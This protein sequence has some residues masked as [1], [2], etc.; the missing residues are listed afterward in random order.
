ME[1]SRGRDA[2]VPVES[3]RTRYVS[4]CFEQKRAV[5]ALAQAGYSARRGELCFRA[6][7]DQGL[8]PGGRAEI[9][10]VGRSGNLARWA[11]VV[12]LRRAMA[13]KRTTRAAQ[14]PANVIGSSYGGDWTG[15]RI[16][17]GRRGRE[18]SVLTNRGDAAGAARIVR[19]D[20][21]ERTRLGFVNGARRLG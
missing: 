6:M 8:V 16:E 10:P 19:G 1:T 5:A 9:S 12:S 15:A 7:A 17:A 20:D 2:D 11:M 13:F 21:D 4:R 18:Y 3:T 14:R